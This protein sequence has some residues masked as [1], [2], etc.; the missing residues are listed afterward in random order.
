MICVEEPKFNATSYYTVAEV[1]RRYGCNRCTVNRAIRAGTIK[2][3]HDALSEA[4]P[5]QRHHGDGLLAQEERRCGMIEYIE[6]Y[7]EWKLSA[8]DPYEDEDTL[9]DP[10]DNDWGREEERDFYEL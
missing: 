7:D 6:G 5:H 1:A 2:V 3:K 8:P 10:A 9:D 4:S